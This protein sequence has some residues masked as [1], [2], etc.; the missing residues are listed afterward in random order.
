MSVWCVLPVD[1]AHLLYVLLQLH[2]DLHFVV[3]PGPV[4]PS[5]LK[6]ALRFA[7]IIANTFKKGWKTRLDLCVKV[8]VILFLL[9]L[10]VS[11]DLAQL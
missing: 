2:K 3:Q 5:G 10:I 4:M 6:D 7:D 11:D 8:S 9:G 1:G